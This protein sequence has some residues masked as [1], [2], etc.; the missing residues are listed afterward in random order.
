MGAFATV[1]AVRRGIMKRLIALVLALVTMLA[2]LAGCG[3]NAKNDKFYDQSDPI[4]VVDGAGRNV[5]FKEPAKTVATNWGGTVDP[6]L[7]AL[8]LADSI[9]GQNSKKRGIID[10]MLPNYDNIP[11][12]G[13]WS[14]DAEALAS[15]SPDVYIHSADAADAFKAANKIGIRAI[16]IKTEGYDDI[17]F[18][19]ELLGK[20]FG[21]EN[22]ARDLID[23]YE[24]I[25][26]L[27]RDRTS[28]LTEDQ[29]K[30]A[31]I[32]GGDAGKVCRTS[33]EIELAGGINAADKLNAKGT[34][35]WPEAGQETIVSW[36]PD[37]IFPQNKYAVWN[38][39]TVL[40]DSAWANTKAVLNGN[41]YD[42]PCPF[43]SWIN[44]NM[45]DCLAVLYM[46]IQMYP[47]LYTDLDF[48][49]IVVDYY[50][51]VYGLDV[52]WEFLNQDV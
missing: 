42:I 46:S 47:E 37:F 7:F 26:G 48:E 49:Q 17:I 30:T 8:G 9:V 32:F 25:L 41:V 34:D 35:R 31:V 12:V 2:C 11:S 10:A 15:V 33:F 18:N 5:S 24:S 22:R 50:K 45:S 13:N 6:Y 21:T 4:V 38:A 19:L 23:Y 40:S 29:K 51:Y 43:E 20:V 16:G 14:L 27:V 28:R 39:E 36:N 1:Y 52:T 44:I 3:N